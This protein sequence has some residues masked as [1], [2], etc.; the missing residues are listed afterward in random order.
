VLKTNKKYFGLENVVSNKIDEAI[1]FNREKTA[2]LL[3]VLQKID[4]NIVFG[5]VRVISGRYFDGKWIFK[6]SMS[7]VYDRDYFK[8]YEGNN[9]E[10]ISKLGRYSV[11]TD[12]EPTMTGCEIDEQY[13][14]EHM[15]S[16]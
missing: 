8:A 2:C 6:L 10:V 13:W 9:F 16:D 7:Y 14:F 11:L 4:T 3:L 15:T 12:G 5:Q 1:F